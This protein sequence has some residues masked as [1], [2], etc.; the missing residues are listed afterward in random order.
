MAAAK[1]CDRCGDFFIEQENSV[2]EETVQLILES[3]SPFFFKSKEQQAIEQLI[4]LCPKCSKSLSKWLRGKEDG[5]G[6][7]ADC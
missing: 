6:N 2:I 7:Q 1:K 4:D 3:L 5:N